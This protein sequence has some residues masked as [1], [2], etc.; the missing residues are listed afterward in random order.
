MSA[1]ITTLTENEIDHYSINEDNPVNKLLQNPEYDM[2]SFD[3]KNIIIFILVII[4]LL[5]ML[6]INAIDSISN[7]IEYVANALKPVLGSILSAFAYLTGTTINTT[8][9]VV[10]DT[11]KAGIDVVEDTIQSVGNLLIDVSNREDDKT[12]VSDK[13]EKSEKDEPTDEP[14]PDTSET[15]IQNSISNKKQSWCL[16]GDYNNRRS[17]ASVNDAEKCM[18]GQIFPSHESCLNP[19]LITNVLPDKQRVTLVN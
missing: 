1:A 14:E 3:I 12:E 16:V 9:D 8:T 4:L 15:S 13:I 10:S 2:S 6:G 18:S 19:N 11:A 17:C 5:M 7:L